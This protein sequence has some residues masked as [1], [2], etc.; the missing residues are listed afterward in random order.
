MEA[1]T[2][3]DVPAASS[4]FSDAALRV[5]ARAQLVNSLGD[6]AFYVASVLYFTLVVGLSPAQVGL[7]LSLAWGL[8][9]AMSAPIGT[10]ADRV[11]LRR[12]A[13]TLACLVAVGLVLLAFAP[14]WAGF[15]AAVCVYA[16]AQSGLAAVR[17]AL[18]V[19]MVD[20]RDRVNARARLQVLL[21][22][23]LGIGAALGTTALIFGTEAAFVSLLLADAGLFVLTAYILSRLPRLPRHSSPRRAPSAQRPRASSVL[24]DTRYL[25]ATLLNAVL[26]LYMPLLSVLLPVWISESTAAPSWTIGL[27]FVTNTI[28]VVLLQRRVARRVVSL[29]TAARSVL[30]GGILLAAACAVLASSSVLSSPQLAVLVLVAGV[31]VLVVGETLIASGSWEVGFALANPQH[32]GQWQGMYLSGIPLGRAVGPLLLLGWVLANST[33][34]WLALGTLFVVCAAALAAVATRWPRPG[35]AAAVTSHP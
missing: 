8:G 22:A 29:R 11:G 18:L 12:S 20:A 5:L 26:Y 2:A 15:L 35:R 17:Q 19:G 25:T 21:N 30:V 1:T 9:F 7:G 34:G 16:A 33:A 14:G 27:L 24:R 31:V 6:G 23:G 13:V 10:V 3:A 4:Q 32:P 28:G